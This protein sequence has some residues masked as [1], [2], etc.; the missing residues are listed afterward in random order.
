[1]GQELLC[2]TKIHPESE[3]YKGNPCPKPP[4]REGAR[5]TDQGDL[6]DARGPKT[7]ASL[8]CGHP[9]RAGPEKLGVALTVPW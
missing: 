8:L 1:M 7:S 9:T 6:E 4:K 3:R 5:I 2:T